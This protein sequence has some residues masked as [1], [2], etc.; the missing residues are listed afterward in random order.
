MRKIEIWYDKPNETDVDCSWTSLSKELNGCTQTAMDYSPYPRVLALMEYARPDVILTADGE[1]FLILELTQMNPSGHNLPQRFSC[2]VR[3]AELGVPSIYYYL[4]KARRSESD[5]NPRYANIRI[6]LGQLRLVEIFNTPSVSIIW[7]TNES[8][9]QAEVGAHAHQ[10]LA[11]YVDHVV[12]LARTGTPLSSTD[13]KSNE[14]YEEMK[15]VIGKY[16]GSTYNNNDSYNQIV[17]NGECASDR[18][19]GQ[20]ISPP[21][22]CQLRQTTI[23]LKEEY[24]RIKNTKDIPSNKKTTQLLSR[25][26]SLIYTG[27]ANKNKDGPEHPYPG[28]LTLLDILYARNKKG[29]VTRDREY[30]LIF[31]LPIDLQ[32]FK[33]K[34]FDRQTGLNILM[35]FSD[36]IVLKDAVVVGGFLRNVSAGAVLVR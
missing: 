35:E 22:S 6:P 29:M 33:D 19:F 21:K 20:R 14:C 16:Y 12:R 27:T 2:L 23:F 4:E 26:F 30:N 9:L 7:P 36:L 1:P 34:A 28:Y 18:L 13:Q 10:H 25:E 8:T 17:E 3:A 11:D 31:K 15:A 24:L 32:T 5:P